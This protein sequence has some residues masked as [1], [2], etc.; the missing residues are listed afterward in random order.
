[1]KRF[2][3]HLY[4]FFPALLSFVGCSEVFEFKE[5]LDRQ[6][7]VN[8]ILTDNSVQTLSLMWTL[9]TKTS[10]VEGI[11]GADVTL[12]DVT[13]GGPV[14]TFS[15]KGNGNYQANYTPAQ[16]HEYELTINIPDREPITAMTRFPSKA[17]IEYCPSSLNDCIVFF[18]VTKGSP[19][20]S[21]FFR[22]VPFYGD[23]YQYNYLATTLEGVD[24]FNLSEM[25]V[26]YGYFYRDN[27][28]FDNET[29]DAILSSCFHYGALRMSLLS[30]D[31]YN[32]VF[33]VLTFYKYTGMPYEGGLSNP[34]PM[35]HWTFVTVSEEYDLY[36]KDLLRSKLG[37]WRDMFSRFNIYSN[38]DSAT[39]IFGAMNHMTTSHADLLSLLPREKL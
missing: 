27:M 20:I 6:V 35:D 26:G 39:G 28:P 1:M 23:S 37:E 5:V 30:S 15:S 25:P 24:D 12:L 4:C 21:W 31:V 3:F 8:C 9:D 16:G 17:K 29:C 38:I 34:G 10:K 7:V 36:L 2:C 19:D 14:V 11:D 13:G 18:R 32:S 22:V 33:P